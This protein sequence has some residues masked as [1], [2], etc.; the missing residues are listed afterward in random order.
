MGDKIN[1]ATIRCPKCGSPGSFTCTNCKYEIRFSLQW[2]KPEKETAIKAEGLKVK[3][4]EKDPVSPAEISAI[5]E[6]IKELPL[7]IPDE[8]EEAVKKPEIKNN[9]LQEE[10]LKLKED[11]KSKEEAAIKR[12][13]LIEE[14]KG[15]LQEDI[16]KSVTEAIN[17]IKQDILDKI[18]TENKPEEPQDIKEETKNKEPKRAA[19]G[20]SKVKNKEKPAKK[21]TEKVSE[22]DKK[23][24]IKKPEGIVEEWRREEIEER[25][26]SADESDS[27]NKRIDVI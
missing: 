21:E 3:K 10:E 11:K 14:I 20:S 22:K 9:E 8:I 6:L 12:Q 16:K 2:S 19:A 13:A 4:L 7:N 27:W 17:A 18:K 15:S 1:N 23:E 24:E 25:P 26:S 5:E